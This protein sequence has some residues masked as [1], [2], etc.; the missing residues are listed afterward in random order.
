[1]AVALCQKV[2]ASAPEL[3]R[4]CSCQTSRSNTPGDTPEVYYRRTISIPFLDELIA[5][6]QSHFSDIQQKAV[7]GMR[8]VP[9][10]M[11]DNSLP[12]SSLEQLK[13]YYEED[14]PSPSSLET[15]L[16]L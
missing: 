9:T 3:P 11:M 2:N 16:H 12:T 13:E 6:L 14:L 15:E 8:I 10:V 7:M 4:C 5:H 1:M